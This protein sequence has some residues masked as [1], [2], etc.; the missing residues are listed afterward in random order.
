VTQLTVSA[1]IRVHHRSINPVE[2]LMPKSPS[3]SL[4]AGAVVFAV[5]STLWMLSWSGSFDRADAVV[6]SI[7]GAV[8]G[9]AWYVAMRWQLRRKGLAPREEDSAI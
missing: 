8:V 4:A 1:R 9:C 7:C 6:L 5:L 3:T 2:Q